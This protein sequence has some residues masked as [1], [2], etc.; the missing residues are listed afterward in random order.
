[1]TIEVLRSFTDP[2]MVPLGAACPAPHLLPARKLNRIVREVLRERPP[3]DDLL[4]ALMANIQGQAIPRWWNRGALR[5]RLKL[6][7]IR[8]KNNVLKA[9]GLVFIVAALIACLYNHPF[10][11]V[12]VKKALENLSSFRPPTES[13]TLLGLLLGVFIP[14]I[15]VMRGLSTFGVS[16]GRLAA[17]FTGSFRPSE[18]E[19]P[20]ALRLRF[21]SV[22]GEVTEALSPNRLVIFIDDLDRCQAP[23]VV[24]VL[25]MVNFLVSSGDCYVILGMAREW[26]SRAVGS[27]SR[28]SPPK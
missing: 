1:L 5:F 21:G 8:G 17:L 2:G 19:S 4:T 12:D 14:F 18:I 6:L 11:D 13:R 9:M 10:A 3:D 26:V 23:N 7:A 27:D 15:G 24:R 28:M 16:P 20:T 25:E 22:Y